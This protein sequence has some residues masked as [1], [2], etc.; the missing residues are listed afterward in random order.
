MEL[1]YESTITHIQAEMSKQNYFCT[2]ADIWSCKNRSFLGVTVHWID[3][4]L[5]RRSAALSCS[6]FKGLCIDSAL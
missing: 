4:N 1:L 5:E 3:D 2:T 6:R